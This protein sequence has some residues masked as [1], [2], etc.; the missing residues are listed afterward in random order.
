M[1]T[2]RDDSSLIEDSLCD[3]TKREQM[4]IAYFYFQFVARKARNSTIMIRSLIKQ[5]GG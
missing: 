5:I 1:L 2:T 4:A 3:Q